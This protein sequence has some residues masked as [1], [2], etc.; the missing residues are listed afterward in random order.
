[1]KKNNFAKK[2]KKKGKVRKKKK[3]KTRWITVIIHSVLGVG[4]Q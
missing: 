4:K 1:L 2:R 3:E